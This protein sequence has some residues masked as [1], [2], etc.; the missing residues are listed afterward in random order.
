MHQCSCG[1]APVQRVELSRD[2][3]EEVLRCV[4]TPCSYEESLRLS[5]RIIRSIGGGE[6][7]VMFSGGR[8]SLVVLDLA[9]RILG[10][11]KALYVEVTGNT[12]EKNISYVYIVARELGVELIHL[13][14]RD[15][16][17]FERVVKWG[18]PGP[19]RR[20][21]MTEFKRRPIERFF[22]SNGGRGTV[23]VGVKA[24][25]SP[26]RKKYIVRDGI[27]YSSG[28]RTVVVRPIIHWTREHVLRYIAEHRLPDNPLY[29]ELGESGNCVYCPFIM[30]GLYYHNLM[31]RYPEWYRRIE[32][33]EKKVRKGTPFVS[34]PRRFTLKQL[35]ERS[36]KVEGSASC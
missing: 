24:W 21:C 12:H 20:W 7:Y 28:W 11:V 29:E 6:V 16:E 27:A 1:L 35:I 10:R 32:E 25:D 14:R 8:D 36:L 34:G 33:V 5:E 4:E 30:N 26:R 2:V 13:K 23:V 22:R 9:R 19:G 17:F 18:W 15:M 31:L 3:E